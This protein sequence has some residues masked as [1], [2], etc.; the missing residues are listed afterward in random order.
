MTDTSIMTDHARVSRAVDRLLA[1]T[2]DDDL[3]RVWAHCQELVN[4]LASRGN[5]DQGRRL[6]NAYHGVRL[7]LL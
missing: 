5:I 1:C 3:A 7:S 4:H 6:V 2:T